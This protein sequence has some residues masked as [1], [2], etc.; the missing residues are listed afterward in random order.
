LN[1]IEAIFSHRISRIRVGVWSNV[2]R[3]IRRAQIMLINEA[4]RMTGFSKDTI[5]YY[6]KIGLIRFSRCN[7]G[8]GSYRYFGTSEIKQLQLIK[9]L[10]TYGFKLK[11]I[12]YLFKL[13]ESEL[14]ECSSVSKLVDKKVSLLEARIEQL[15]MMKSRLVTAQQCCTGDCAALVT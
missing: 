11:E 3:E 14:L 7:G 4:A 6:E 10:K 9:M 15:N 2:K 13:V 1:L 8:S 12:K 5:R